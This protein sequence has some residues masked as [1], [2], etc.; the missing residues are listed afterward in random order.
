MLIE[1]ELRARL[2]QEFTPSH[3]Q[4]VNES[5]KHA[6]HAGIAGKETGDTHFKVEIVSHAFAG[7]TPV[8]CHQAVYAV[9]GEL[10]NNPIHALSIDARAAG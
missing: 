7:K 9:V 5:H 3:L 10:M 8:Q 2:Q 6:G 4:V 1:D